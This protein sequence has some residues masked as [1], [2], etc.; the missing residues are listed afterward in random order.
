MRAAWVLPLAVVLLTGILWFDWLHALDRA[1]FTRI[2]AVPLAAS[3]AITVAVALYQLFVDVTFLNP[4]VY[5]A[6]GR[7]SG[8]LMDGNVCGTIAALW[9]GGWQLLSG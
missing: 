6:M 4:T 5:G 9:I 8:T 2:V 7:A 1:E 3:C